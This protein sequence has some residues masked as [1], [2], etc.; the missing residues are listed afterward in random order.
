M[1]KQAGD[2]FVQ[3]LP[4]GQHAQARQRFAQHG[5]RLIEPLHA[6]YGQRADFDT[7]LMQ[8][9]GAMGQAL[10]VRPAALQALDDLREAQPGWFIAQRLLGYMAYA[11]RFGGT[12]AG[13]G[14]RIAHLRELG[15][16]YLHLLP[17]L[18]ARAGDSDGGFA[19]AA[20]DEVEPALGTMADL[21]QLCERLREAGISLC[22]DLV[23][24][25]VAD[26]HAWAKAAAAG[27]AHYRDFFHVFTDRREPDAYEAGLGEV[28][29]EAAP[30]NFSHVPALEG[31]VWTTFYP[32]QWDLNYA[33]PPVFAA[34]AQALLGLA[35]RGVE[36]F[37]LDSAPFLWK[38]QGTA[39][40]NQPEV[41]QLL[42]ALRA[43]VALV[44][45]GVLLKAEA[46]MPSADV[47]RYFGAGGQAGHECQL[48]YHSGMMAA[49]WAGLAEG[50]PSLLRQVLGNTP[51]PPAHTGWIS[52][53]RCH[54]DIVWG[55]LKPE[56]VVAGDDYAQRMGAV[57]AM[58]EGR[59]AGS[60]ARG[61]AFQ[62]GED[63]Q[64]HG[65]NGM[66]A[67]LVGLPQDANAQ[68]DP[69]ALRR[70]QLMLGLA[71][72]AGSVPLIY[73]GDEIGQNNNHADADAAR[74]RAD[75]RW[76]QRPVFDDAQL[77]QARAGQGWPG[78]VLALTRRLVAA[79]RDPRLPLAT[80]VSVVETG[81]PALLVLRRGDDAI[82]L[83]N[84]SDTPMPVDLAALGA[85]AHWPDLLSES[86]PTD[87]AVAAWSVRW[88][89]RP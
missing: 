85:D 89:V 46:I 73:M 56:V 14:E 55:V 12:L 4:A 48:A 51:A 6:L 15:V 25:H 74:L 70:L 28:F 32:Y 63:G 31:W 17:F 23:L 27:D 75:G 86:A 2:A 16:S 20:F 81:H 58:L 65:T 68:A 82:G 35:N 77:V 19:V 11:D 36:V 53:V 34:M 38:R 76:L 57:T 3:A 72:F 45:P 83:F 80:P 8:L 66:T 64:V 37:R 24:N 88:L 13:V 42:C 50:H 87:T 79:R 1:I 84:F 9:C 71:F 44:A 62:A 39:C 47:V 21:E 26:D 49:A 5:A 54:D 60:Y 52:Y 33:H 18:R 67:A 61:V 43:A 59:R 22:A 29:P 7:W 69:A 30:G 78:Q 40:V 41:H 10:A